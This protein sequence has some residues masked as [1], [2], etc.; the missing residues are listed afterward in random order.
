MKCTNYQDL[1]GTREHRVPS[2]QERVQNKA[3]ALA[4]VRSAVV[5]GTCK[6]VFCKNIQG[7]NKQT[8]T[9]AAGDHGWGGGGM[10]CDVP[11]YTWLIG[12]ISQQTTKRS[13]EQQIRKGGGFFIWGS[14]RTWTEGSVRN[15]EAAFSRLLGTTLGFKAQTSCDANGDLDRLCVS[16]C[17]LETDWEWRWSSFYQPDI[18]HKEDSVLSLLCDCFAKKHFQLKPPAR[19][20]LTFKI[21]LLKKL[22]TIKNNNDFAGCLILHFLDVDS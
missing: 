15:R 3:V 22:N 16:A 20:D 7:T 6:W 2:G 13:L 8:Q 5:T 18:R 17:E 12:C 4:H 9:C 21:Q 14:R 19:W 10:C 11:S 1:A